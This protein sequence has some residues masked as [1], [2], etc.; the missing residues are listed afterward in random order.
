MGGAMQ[1]ME[2]RTEHKG[3]ATALE[4]SEDLC[5]GGNIARDL[6]R[7]GHFLGPMPPEP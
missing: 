5:S 3:D 7:V 6:G 4:R 2:C 1:Y